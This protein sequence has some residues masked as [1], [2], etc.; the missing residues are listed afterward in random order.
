MEGTVVDD[1]TNKILSGYLTEHELAKEL[2]RST[3][4]IWRWRNLRQGP[5]YVMLGRTPMYR[6]DSAI[7]WLASRETQAVRRRA[8]RRGIIK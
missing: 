2:R 6:L 1:Q 4:T 7:A 8:T 3:R 5:P